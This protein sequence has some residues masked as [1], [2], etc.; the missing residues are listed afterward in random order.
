MTRNDLTAMGLTEE[1]AGKGR[2][3]LAMYGRELRRTA[4][5]VLENELNEFLRS[6]IK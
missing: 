6:V 3:M 1:Q 5:K 4:P 2:F